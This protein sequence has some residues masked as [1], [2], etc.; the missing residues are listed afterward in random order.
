M[1]ARARRSADLCPIA[2]CE[3]DYHLPDGT[4]AAFVVTL[5][6]LTGDSDAAKVARETGAL[7][8]GLISVVGVPRAPTHPI[9]WMLTKNELLTNV[10]QADPDIGD[11]L[12]GVLVRVLRP[13][14][15]D[16]RDVA[17]GLAALKPPMRASP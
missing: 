1:V 9:V 16:V 17:P 2:C 6:N 11:D 3:Y 12:H 7:A 10:A 15:K 5:R 8:H 4:H 14:F 13:F